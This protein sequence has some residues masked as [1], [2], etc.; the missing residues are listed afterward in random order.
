MSILT[1]DADSPISERGLLTCQ[2]MHK[3]WKPFLLALLGIQCLHGGLR[4]IFTS[5]ALGTNKERHLTAPKMVQT[6]TESKQIGKVFLK[7]KQK[8]DYQRKLN[9]N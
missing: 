4:V 2:F 8:R 9:D 1:D 3:P 7:S 6:G 5:Y